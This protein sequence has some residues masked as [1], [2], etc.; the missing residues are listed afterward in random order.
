M[1]ESGLPAPENILGMT[2][3]WDCRSDR[4]AIVRVYDHW[5]SK[6]QGR[7]M[8]SRQDI[9]PSE[10]RDVLPILQIYNVAD[11][12]NAYSVRLLGTKIATAM[13]EDTTGQSF[14][15]SSTAPLVTRMLAVIQR[16]VRLR[17]PLIASAE[18]TAIE[19]MSFAPIESI[20]L[21]LSE[22]LVDVHAVLGATVIG[23]GGARN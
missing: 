19:K 7:L 8:P 20:F 15:G 14:D 2:L 22:N 16:V 23:A 17:R 5:R 4:S 13:G 1:T 3:R 9:V 18:R 11:Q 12:G 6:M 21:P 10:L